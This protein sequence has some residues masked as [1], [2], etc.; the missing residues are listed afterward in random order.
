MM[1]VVV[2]TMGMMGV[3]VIMKAVLIMMVLMVVTV[4]MVGRPCWV[5]QRRTAFPIAGLLR[6]MM[7]LKCKKAI[8]KRGASIEFPKPLGLWNSV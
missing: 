4:R 1:T 7:M 6:A 5:T 8:S 3:T 2:V